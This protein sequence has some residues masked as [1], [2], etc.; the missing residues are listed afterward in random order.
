MEDFNTNSTALDAN[1]HSLAVGNGAPALSETVEDDSIG[2][3]LEAEFKSIK[4]E[5]EKADTK[6]EKPAT[7]PKAKVEETAPKKEEPV[8]ADAP[9]TEVKDE[10]EAKPGRKQSPEDIKRAEERN[11][12]SV[13][14]QRFTPEAR[15]KWDAV[16]HPV[17]AELYR[18]EQLRESEVEKYRSSHER[19][20]QIRQF[21]EIAKTNGR[22]LKDT[23]ATIS[24]FEN[25]MRSNPIAAL[26]M[27]LR[28]SGP[29]KQDGSP[30][31]LYEV[32]QHIVNQ[33][34]Q[35]FQQQSRAVNPQQQQQ[36][37]RNPEIDQLRSEIHSM[38]VEQTVVPLVQQFAAAHPDF[39]QLSPQI[40]G[41]LDSGV[42][43]KLYGDGL[44]HEQK[45][46]EAYRMAGGS[47]SIQSPTV[48]AA[49]SEPE[50]RFAKSDAG[51][52]SVR[53]APSNGEDAASDET[54]T[55]LRDLLKKE[56]KKL[57]A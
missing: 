33:G 4:A 39:E 54:E 36:P 7:E 18:N 14:A 53:G 23:L 28:E 45:L 5:T 10:E 27:A 19:Y 32:A 41:I 34:P 49:P 3:V 15:A 9:K 17:K 55:D 1:D 29:R 13:V 48:D 46:S 16:P 2:A 52:K 25:M 56:M 50:A 6:T 30:V 40:K 42:V 47:P 43:D 37:Q 44:T 22:D 38:K 26:E 12:Y 24:Q 21:D 11:R 31:S 57:V 8:K 51:T 35:A 20:E